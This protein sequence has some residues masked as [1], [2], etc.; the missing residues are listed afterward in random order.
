MGLAGVCVIHPDFGGEHL[1]IFL[2]DYADYGKNQL[3]AVIVNITSWREHKDQTLI[4]Q[5]GDH[6]FIT[7]KSVI[8]YDNACLLQ[9]WQ[10]EFVLSKG[11]QQ[12]PAS[13]EL[14][15][16]I[17]DGLLRSP[18]TPRDV[19]DFYEQYSQNTGGTD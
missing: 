11:K 14:L 3:V 7:K 13:K 8:A 9:E 19:R 6:D 12:P 5:P 2:T 1:C 15:R 16:R 17:G 10:V 4:L 18:F